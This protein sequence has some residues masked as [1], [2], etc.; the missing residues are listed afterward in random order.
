MITVTTSDSSALYFIS[1]NSTSASNM[2]HFHKVI[3]V[4]D[5]RKSTADRLI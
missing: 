1:G 2:I 5:L 3:R 4:N